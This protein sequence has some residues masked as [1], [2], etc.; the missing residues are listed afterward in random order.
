MDFAEGRAFEEAAINSGAGQIIAKDVRNN[1]RL[2]FDDEQ[3]A[4]QWW[5]RV[6]PFVPPTFGRWRACGLNERFR[7]YRYGPGQRFVQHYDGSYQRSKDEN[8][9]LTLMAY[10]NDDFTGGTTRFDLANRA[11]PLIVTPRSGTALVF[12]H[13][14]LHSGDEV[15]AGRKYVLRTDVMYRRDGAL[16]VANDA[17]SY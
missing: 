2:L 16:A 17:D 5:H 10:L 9:W 7:C 8:S 1:D 14:R 4:A 6:E 11:E 12:M 13:H 3:L 15:S